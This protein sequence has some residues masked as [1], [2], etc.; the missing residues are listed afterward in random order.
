MEVRNI[1]LNVV[2]RTPSKALIMFFTFMAVGTMNYRYKIFYK[3]YNDQMFSN[4]TEKR[5]IIFQLA[6][7]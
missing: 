5:K 3:I 7:K 6:C 2:R 1:L 4:K